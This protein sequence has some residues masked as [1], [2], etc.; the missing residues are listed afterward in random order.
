[1]EIELRFLVVSSWARGNT[2]CPSCWLPRPR[3]GAEWA[4]AL[5]AATGSVKWRASG[6]S[7]PA[8]R[9]ARLAIGAD[10]TVYVCS[11]DRNLHA[12][13][14]VTGTTKWTFTGEVIDGEPIIGSDGTLYLV[15]GGKVFALDGE[16]RAKKWEF[17]VG[18]AVATPALGADGTL[19]F[20]AA[21][22]KVYALDGRTG[23]KKWEFLTGGAVK[24]SPA[25][26]TDGILYVTSTDG[27]LYAIVAGTP[28]AD[29]PWPMAGQN[30]GRC[31]C[32]I[33]STR[34]G[35]HRGDRNSASSERVW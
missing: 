6:I 18:S 15:G 12:V 33:R 23:V 29:S 4:Y 1:M 9:I 30:P 2:L 28:P 3:L 7:G 19:F 32:M 14:G 34:G 21:D 13:D 17:T 35:R 8:D 31:S 16:S 5:D 22:R 27:Y 20:G 25:L 26:T 10:G 11:T 24:S